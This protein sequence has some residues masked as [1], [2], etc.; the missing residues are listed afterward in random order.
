MSP[1]HRLDVNLTIKC[2]NKHRWKGEWQIG[3]YN[4]YNSITPYQIY[5]KAD[6]TGKKYMQRGIFGFIPSVAYNFEF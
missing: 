6:D 1:N 4:V 2:K 5:F 3:A